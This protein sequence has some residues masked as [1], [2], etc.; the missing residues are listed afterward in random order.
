MGTTPPV[1]V[2]PDRMHAIV[3]RKGREGDPLEAMRPEE[4]AVPKLGPNDVLV[5]VMAAG[6]NFNGIWAARG[7]PVS[8]MRGTGDDFHIA[9]SD[10]SGIV[11]QVGSN[12]RR[13]KIGDEVVVH[14]NQSCGQCP[15]CNGLDPL[16]CSEQRIWGYETNYGSFAQFAKVQ[17]QQLLPKP[18]R[19]GWIESASYGLTYFTAYRML[20]DQ[21]KVRAGDNVLVWGASG[22]LGIFAV[23]LCKATGANAIAVVSSGRKAELARKLGAA[24]TIDRRD[25]EIA[26]GQNESPEQEKRRLAEMKRFGKALREL[27]GGSDPDVVFE[28]VGQQTF[29]ASVFLAKRFGKIVICG[30]TSGYHLDFDVR[31]LWMRQKQIIG[32]HFANAYEADRANQ[33]IIEGK[34]RPYVD[35]VFA[36]E[37]T[38]EAHEEMAANR[39]MG[40]MVITVGAEQ[41][42]RANQLLDR[43]PVAAAAI[44]A[45]QA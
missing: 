20:L 43:P 2:V 4:V 1:G 27:T 34:I 16:A 12:V 18:P 6:V 31:H 28:H 30:A 37:Q 45:Y 38:P 29:P 9:G 7:K 33:L 25:F 21:A 8:V 10:A 32:S 23:Q 24:A 5:Y 22:G 11:W 17:S 35:R 13:W 19:L 3:I 41:D 26:K 36:F 14:C 44:P 39:H 42:E 15:E 40:K